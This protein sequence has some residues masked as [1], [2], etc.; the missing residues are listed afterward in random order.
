MKNERKSYQEFNDF[1][2]DSQNRRK[3][4][5]VRDSVPLILPPPKVVGHQIMITNNKQD[6]RKNRQAESSSMYE[7]S[8]SFAESS[9]LLEESSSS[10]NESSSLPEESSSSVSEPFSSPEETSSSD[11]ESSSLPEESSSSD[12]ESSSLPEESSSSDNEP[13]SSPEE[14][15]SSDNEPSSLS[16]ESS[17]SDNEFSSLPEETSSSDNEPSSLLEESS[18]SDNEFSSLPEWSLSSHE[19]PLSLEDEYSLSNEEPSSI[20]EESPSL[21]DKSFS[22]H[23]E[24]SSMFEEEKEEILIHHSQYE[25]PLP[26]IKIPVL[27]AVVNIDIDIFDTFDLLF[28]ITNVSKI[29]LSVHSLDSHVVLPSNIVFLKGI[30]IADIEFVNEK[31]SHSHQTMKIQI[32]WEKTT[33][34]MWLYPPSM[35]SSSQVEYTFQSSHHDDE[36]SSIYQSQEEYAEQIQHDLQSI[37]FVWH[38]E[39]ASKGGN[40]TIQIQGRAKICLNLIQQ[41]YINLDYH[42]SRT[43]S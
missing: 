21:E 43:N 35:P 29:E 10:D 4:S 32:P 6:K 17:S 36:N 5:V 28:P 40:S 39:L 41:Q 26:I 30:F 34:I 37:N 38:D 25:V 8:S 18:S 12:N 23:D 42:D 16:E 22:Q 2:G 9:S 3:R 13:S 27:L 31:L 15:S 7:E 24:S 14:T 19:E 1:Q 11:N 33:N 20:K